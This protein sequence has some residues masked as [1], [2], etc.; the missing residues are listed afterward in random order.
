MGLLHLLHQLAPEFGCKLS[1]AH[2][3]H[4]L[5]GRASA[6]DAALV[7]RVAQRLGLPCDVGS[8]DVKSLA[9]QT[10]TSIEMAARTARHTFLAQ[11][12]RRRRARFVA[13]AHHADD[14]VELFF[15][16]LMRGASGEGMGGMR[17]LSP[18]PFSR[19]V[20]LW[21]PLLDTN[22]A[23]LLAW[24]QSQRI[25]FREDATNHDLDLERNWLRQDLLPRLRARQPGFDAAVWRTMDSVGAEADMVVA[26]AEKWLTS[27]KKS[28][29]TRLPLAVQRRVLQRQIVQ[30]GVAADF[31]LIE[32]LRADADKAVSAGSG[33]LV[34]R[35]SKGIVQKSS[36]TDWKRFNGSQR[37]LRLNA[38]ATH[39]KIRFAGGE[40]QWRLRARP[41]GFKPAAGAGV[42]CFDAEKI[43]R[44]LVLR[45]WQA[46]D[47]FWPIGLSSPTKLQDWF[48][49]RKVPA[50][51]R[52]ALV[53]AADERGELFWV[54]G[55]RIGETAKVTAATRR[56]LEWHWVRR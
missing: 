31:N 5:R 54:E 39:G 29:F 10:R 44:R 14:Q 38:G 19:R 47:R 45:H 52:H 23:E 9:K 18:S 12:A 15:L 24:A 55:Q 22:K 4:H 3:N 30:L 26:L 6:A 50:A 35:N 13:L 56:L 48:T 11:C 34:S 41:K 40:L 43:G 21:R 42:E 53:L 27:K 46:G 1:V 51:E 33:V 7:K 32:T 36:A 49:N 2:L 28:S 8:A 37:G 25:P 17:R 16:R 20:T